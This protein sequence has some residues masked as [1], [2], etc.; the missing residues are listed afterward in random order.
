MTG[1]L[2]IKKIISKNSLRINIIDFVCVCLYNCTS[3]MIG[4][5]EAKILTAVATILLETETGS[6]HFPNVD[7]GFSYQA[8]QT[9]S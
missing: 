3:R 6:K 5:L 7:S 4:L 8:P 9:E 1:P 2:K